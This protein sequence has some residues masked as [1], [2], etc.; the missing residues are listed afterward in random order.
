M[1]RFNYPVQIPGRIKTPNGTGREK[2]I[3]VQ[4]RFLL[5]Y[6]SIKQISE[7]L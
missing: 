6:L 2:R 7:V 1:K 5:Y 3:L 4:S